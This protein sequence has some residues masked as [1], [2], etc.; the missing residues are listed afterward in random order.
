MRVG[1]GA[2]R[3]GLVYLLLALVPAAAK[4]GDGAH[5][6]VAVRA[7][8]PVATPG[9]SLQAGDEEDLPLARLGDEVI[10]REQ[11]APDV[12]FRIYRLRVDIHSLLAQ[13]TERVVEER[14]LAR[15]AARRDTTPEA[16]LEEAMS[17][18][19]PVHEDDVDDWLAEHPGEGRGPPDRVRARVRL[20]L[21]ERRR[22]EKRLAL[23]ERLR[24]EADYVWLLAP[25]EPPRIR[26]E[27][28]DA[29]ARGPADAP[30]TI[31]HFASFASEPSLRSA[32]KLQ[33]LRD[34]FPG[35]L[36]LVH[37]SFLAP[38]DEAGLLAAQLSVVA[39]RKGRFWDFHDAVFAREAALDEV[40]LEAAA[41]AAGLAGVDL[42]AL[43]AGA[44]ASTLRRVREDQEA[45]NRAGVPR[46]PTLFVNGRY[47][48]GFAPYEEL[49]SLVR[50]ELDAAAGIDPER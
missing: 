33:R 45:G 46:E 27:V 21:E 19:E 2:V 24:A 38:R 5:E 28:G 13:E 14:L 9:R 18:A 15:E 35:R 17:S 3:S 12:A 47:A 23:M 42:E 29:P 22:I 32:K 25:P 48:S 34:E 26:L 11:V 7:G 36:R 39:D 50:Q 20:F 44:E 16:L 49:R 41:R 10:T 8:G 37:R 4:A 30:V 40:S 43:E 6:E 31:F 1:A